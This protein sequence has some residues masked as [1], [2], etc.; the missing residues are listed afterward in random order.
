VLILS[1]T[2]NKHL[3]PYFSSSELLLVLLAIH[4]LLRRVSI[5][6]FVASWQTLRDLAQFMMVHTLTS[7]VSDSDNAILNLILLLVLLDC[8]SDTESLTTS[9]TY[10]VSDKISTLLSTLRIPLFGAALSLCLGGKGLLGRTLAFVGVNTLSSLIFETVPEPLWPISLL[11]F[12]HQVKL[13]LSNKAK[14]D[15]LNTFFNFGLYRASDAIYNSLSG[16]LPPSTIFMAFLFLG[17]LQ[18]DPVLTGICVLVFVQG[19]SSWF[20]GQLGVI[21][22]DPVLAALSLVTVVHF[23]SVIELKPNDKK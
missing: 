19:G 13:Q 15:T 6:G 9:V 22:T 23:I 21:S 16:N 10:I 3:T 14:L 17:S 18:T 1:K 5:P 7:N 4:T 12:A 2:L 8:L 11:Y 20:L